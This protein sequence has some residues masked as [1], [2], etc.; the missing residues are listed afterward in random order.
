MAYY[1]MGYLLGILPVSILLYSLCPKRVRWMSLLAVSL[2]FSWYFSRIL[3][4]YPLL[5]TLVIYFVGNRM[6][7]LD[8][9]IKAASQK[10]EK[11]KIQ[12]YKKWTLT[13]GVLALV[14]I[15]V[16]LKYYNFL[17][18]L[19]GQIHLFK[20]GSPLRVKKLL[21]PMGISFYTLQAISYMADVYWGKISRE[22]NVGKLAF[23]IL[24]YPT[25]MEGPIC[26]YDKK[27]VSVFEGK[28][29]LHDNLQ[30]GFVKILWGLMKKMVIAD[31]LYIPVTSIFSHYSSYHGSM[32]LVGACFYTIQLYM[33]F[34]GCIDIAIGS[35][36]I[37][38]VV[39]PENF[40]QPFFA[41]SAAEFWRRWHISLGLW[42]KTYVFY[43]VSAS[44]VV[45]KWN[46]YS[47]KKLGK[48]P[49]KLGV[50]ALTLFPVWLINGLWHGA[51]WGYILYGMYYFVILFT[52]VA[53]EEPWKKFMKLCHIDVERKAYQLF[54]ILKTWAIIFCGELIFRGERLIVIK[55]MLAN[56]FRDFTFHGLWTRHILKLGLQRPDYF[57]L[58]VSLL[59]VALV[60][61]CRERNISLYGRIKKATTWK[62]WLAYY[63]IIFFIIIFGAYGS[64]YAAV[65]MIY[66][67]F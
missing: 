27:Y 32:I 62:R 49:A 44:R 10:E 56:L 48:Y 3:I 2:V 55:T 31:R 43:P 51:W 35:A 15:L 1:E 5:S 23:Y 24:Y 13:G 30:E 33:E 67:N 22:R 39:L 16:Y 4:I 34:S 6:H 46:K 19:A 18:E 50:T 9:K 42:L 59:W 45:K 11:K 57:I 12:T 29:I 28:P 25:L 64:G 37:F 8:E 60:D 54:R 52:E 7:I 61:V 21:M 63:G 65:D 38:G 26:N 47:K 66:A 17:A 53:I 58:L 20:E 14:A 40:R 36:R 41:K